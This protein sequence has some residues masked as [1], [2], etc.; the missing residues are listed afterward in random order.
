M[1]STTIPCAHLYLKSDFENVPM[2]HCTI[3]LY[4]GLKQTEK[5]EKTEMTKQVG[6]QVR[7]QVWEQPSGTASG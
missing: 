2:Y 3:Q 5:T 6:E 7:V 4:S 1:F